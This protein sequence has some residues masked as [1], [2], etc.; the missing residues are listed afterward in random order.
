MLHEL[1]WSCYRDS[2]AQ[3]PCQKES[4]IYL[5]LRGLCPSTSIDKFY[6]PKNINEKFVLLG[7][8]STAVKYN[9][10]SERWDMDVNSKARKT[11]GSS[12]NSFGSFLLGKNARVVIF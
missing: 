4:P 7:I 9:P 6:Y 2:G 1:F 11:T 3:C 8:T 10:A 5:K 12:G